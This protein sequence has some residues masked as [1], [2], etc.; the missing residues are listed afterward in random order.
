MNIA[1]SIKKYRF[2]DLNDLEK[3]ISCWA[4]FQA[5]HINKKGRIKPCP[6]SMQNNHV[7]SQIRWSPE[8]SLKQCWNDMVYEEMRDESI[9]GSLHNQWCEYCIKQCEQNKPPSSLDYDYTGGELSLNHEYPK[10]IELELSN[11]CNYKCDACGPW[12]SSEWAK[13]MGLEKDTRFHS[14]FDDETNMKALVNDLRTFIHEVHRINFTGGEP[15]AQPPVYAILK[16]IEEENAK[17]GIHFTTNGSVMNGAVRR[18]AQRPNTSFTVSLDSI[19]PIVY[20]S[21]R[22]NGV[23]SEVMKNIDYLVETSKN[24][25]GASFVIT[26]KNVMELPS[27]LSWC[28]EKGIKFSYHILENMGFRDWEKELKPISIEQENKIYLSSL[29]KYLIDSR[30]SITKNNDEELYDRNMFMYD[31]Y[32]ERLK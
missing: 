12:C 30:D 15:F 9:S 2:D 22:V 18:M 29:K 16:M 11:K 17:V 5:M 24:R 13:E 1:E 32:I 27:I 4:P 21:I 7:Y 26:K 28:N 20:P 6:F 31:R 14:I 25:V 8:K 3:K 19:D 23:L 10:E